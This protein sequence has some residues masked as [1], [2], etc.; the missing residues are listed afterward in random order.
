MISVDDF[1]ADVMAWAERIG[2]TP[3]EIHVRPMK[4]KWGSCSSRGRLTFATDL[5][6]QPEE[7]RAEVIVHELL[8]LRYPSHGKMFR[9]LLRAYLGRRRSGVVGV[10]EFADARPGKSEALNAGG[11]GACGNGSRSH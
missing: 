9:A 2:V 11:G 3:K 1:K 8:H 10:T 5:L 6:G 4:R 7:K